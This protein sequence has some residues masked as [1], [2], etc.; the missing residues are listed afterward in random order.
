[1][2][3]IPDTV[4]AA[5]GAFV[6][7][8]SLTILLL[9]PIVCFSPVFPAPSPNASSLSASLALSELGVSA[10]NKLS[11][12]LVRVR[13]RILGVDEREGERGKDPGSEWAAERRFLLRVNEGVRIFFFAVREGVLIG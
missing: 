2:A 11:D 1:M 5:D 13:L 7:S 12:V 4:G 9:L 3:P 6:K 10:G 8:F